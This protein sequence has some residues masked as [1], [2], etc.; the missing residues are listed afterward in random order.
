MAKLNWA[1][2][3]ERFRSIDFILSLP[4]SSS[5]CERGFSLMKLTKTAYRNKMKSNTLSHLLTVKLHSSPIE[6]FNPEPAIRQW[7]SVKS[8]TKISFMELLPQCQQSFQRCRLL[9]VRKQPT[10]TLVSVTESDYSDSESWDLSD[11]D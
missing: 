2:V 5:I 9:P 3:N 10:L 6:D 4:A 11:S 8:H 1:G 7:F